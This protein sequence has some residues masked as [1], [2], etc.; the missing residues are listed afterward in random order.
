MLRIKSNSPITSRP[1]SAFST[2]T[3]SNT[4]R[5]RSRVRH[6]FVLQLG[7]ICR[8]EVHSRLLTP[9]APTIAWL[10]SASAR[11]RIIHQREPIFRGPITYGILGALCGRQSMQQPA[12]QFN[13]R[14]QSG[15]RAISRLSNLCKWVLHNPVAL[16]GFLGALGLSGIVQQPVA[17]KLCCSETAP[18]KSRAQQ[19]SQ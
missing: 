15:S 5:T 4:G 14:L 17:Q 13:Q 8:E 10:K 3:R 16:N 1:L 6:G 9:A 18:L 7:F 12:A 11:K 2:V 19:T